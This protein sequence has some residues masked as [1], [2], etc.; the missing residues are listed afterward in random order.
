M[1]TKRCHYQI[2]LQR[3]DANGCDSPRIVTPGIVPSDWCLRCPVW[4]PVRPRNFFEQTQALWVQE[5]RRGNY[6]PQA[7]RC[8]GC[9]TVKRRTGAIQFVWPYWHGGANGDEIRW[10]VRS[11][12]KH[13]SGEAKIT[14][15]GDRPPWY[16]GHY[17][18]KR[19]VP[20][21]T[22]NRCYRDMLSKVWM[23]ATHAEIDDEF[24]WMMD[25]IYLIKQCTIDDLATP[26]A[27]KWMET[28]A[29]S[30]QRRKY[31]TMQILKARGATTHDYATH[32]PHYVEKTV[33][34]QM[35]DEHDLH[36]NTVLWEVLYGNLHRDTPIGTRPFFAR[37]QKRMPTEEYHKRTQE[38]VIMNHTASAWCAGLRAYLEAMLPEP[39]KTELQS[40]QY[41]PKYRKTQA[42][43]R[44][45][46]RRPRHT[47]RRVIERQQNANPTPDDHS[48]GIH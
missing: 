33:L 34:R 2:D 22:P 37:F 21:A 1:N 20:P 26:R 4:E 42:A 46:K 43:D 48:I 25:D 29:N 12:E 35:Y 32:L 31:N 7:K 5:Q 30:W 14:I 6:T 13:F 39:S 23:M 24:V 36:R 15:I 17:I 16:Y 27:D 47:H 19:R 10:S 38:A 9:G 3:S 40:T 44:T 28:K 11:V 8:S 41:V 45:V 18:P